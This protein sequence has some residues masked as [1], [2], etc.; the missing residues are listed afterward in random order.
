MGGYFEVFYG[1]KVRMKGGVEFILKKV[2]NETIVKL[3]R[4]QAY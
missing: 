2:F 4:R 3:P 1:F